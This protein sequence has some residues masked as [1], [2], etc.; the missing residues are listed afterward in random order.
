MLA[1]KCGA[2]TYRSHLKKCTAGYPGHAYRGPGGAWT[3]NEEPQ[4]SDA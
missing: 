1:C 4:C 2:H 3:T